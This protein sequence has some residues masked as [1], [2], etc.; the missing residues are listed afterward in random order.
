MIDFN[1]GGKFMKRNMHGNGQILKQKNGLCKHSHTTLF[2][3]THTM[4]RYST[5]QAS[6]LTKLPPPE[7]MMHSV[8]IH[9]YYSRYNPHAVFLTVDTSLRNSHMDIKAYLRS[10][11]QH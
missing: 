5:F 3:C 1:W 11:A 10:V 8:L 2:T 9:D 7:T 6:N 4:H